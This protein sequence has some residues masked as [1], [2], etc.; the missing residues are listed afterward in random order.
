MVNGELWEENNHGCQRLSTEKLYRYELR[1]HKKMCASPLTLYFL[2][3]GPASL[4]YVCLILCSQCGVCVYLTNLLVALHVLSTVRSSSYDID[5]DNLMDKVFK[6]K[7]KSIS[8]FL[9]P[10]KYIYIYIYIY[11]YLYIYTL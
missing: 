9:F 7:A 4:I 5:K 2:E 1:I 11:I 8:L 3:K 10:L 6:I